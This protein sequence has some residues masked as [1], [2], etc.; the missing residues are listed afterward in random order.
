MKD[1]AWFKDLTSNVK[2]D[3]AAAAVSTSTKPQAFIMKV[4]KRDGSYEEISFDKVLRRIRTLW[5]MHLPQPLSSDISPDEIAQ[6]VCARIY[7]S[8]KTSELD[9]LAAQICAT[10]VTTHPDY[11]V[12]AAR[13]AISNHHKN[14]SP[15]FSET[16]TML[17]NAKDVHGNHNP[18]VSEELMDIVM[19]HRDKL[20]SIIDYDR[21]YSFDYFGFKT[22]ERSYLLKIDK[23]PV[24]RPQHMWMRVALGIHAYDIKEALETYEYMSQRFFTHATPTLF[25]A[26]TPRAQLSSCYLLDVEDSVTGMYKTVSDCAQISKYAGGIGVHIHDIRSRGSHIRGTNGISSGIIPM[27]R[28][29]NNTARHINQAGKRAGSIAMYLEPWHSDVEAFLDIRKNQGAE[30]ERCRDLFTALW[31]PDLFMTRVQQ[32]EEWSL[33]CP[34]RCPGL[35]DV[36]G[37]E[38]DALY[39]KYEAEGRAI[40]KVKAQTI[41]YAILKSQI[42]TG[43]PYLC[44]K[45]ACNKKSNQ[46][47]IGTIK[48]SNLCVAPETMILTD[49]G[50]VCIA[51]LEDQQVFVWN[52]YEFSQTTVRKT[53]TMQKLM[54][55][56]FSNSKTLR[57]TP[58][59][60]FYTSN[61]GTVAADDLVVGT[62]LR[63]YVLPSLGDIPSL[64]MHIVVT[65]INQL[66]EYDDTYCFNE[67]LR[68]AGVFNGILTGQCSEIIE[69][70]DPEQVAS[71]NL[72][73]IGLPTFVVTKTDTDSHVYFDYEALHK[74]SRVVT[75][76]LNKVIDRTFYPIPEARYANLLHRPL[77]IGVQGLADVFALL[78]LPF[79]SPEASEVNRRIFEVIYH[80]CMTESA[81][82]ARRRAEMRAEMRAA[83]SGDDRADALAKHL[84]MIPQEAAL[85]AYPGAY[86]TFV[87]SPVS[88]GVLQFD[89]WGVT[90]LPDTGLDWEGLRADIAKWGIRN[91]LLIANMPTASS[92]QILGFNECFEPFTSNMFQRQTMAGEFTIINKYLIRDLLDLGLWSLDM[93]DRI[94]GGG[95]SVQAIT[96]IPENIRAL[97]KTVWEIKQKVLIDQAAD[98][99]AF[100]C[101]S[102]SLN[103]FVEDTDFNKL[104]SMHFY[105]WKKGLKT[106]VYYLRT[107]PKARIAAYTLAPLNEAV[108][109]TKTNQGP[110]TD[111]V[112]AC[113]RDNPEGCLMCSS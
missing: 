24:E 99:G 80:G 71:C 30:E 26:G 11:G 48:S 91:S 35:S 49:K 105:A 67:P 13:I 38:F 14:T 83:V 65:D 32:N 93:K 43:T 108:S 68:H 100:V 74:V 58:Y 39:E 109:P 5:G 41:W 17:Y 85:T 89:M 57:C 70:S 86:A 79:D 56:H 27:L 2:S 66:G 104:T 12:L 28:V 102:Q 21:D 78:R 50:D 81:A 61:G 22:L 77:G 34:D 106:G 31:I 52:G 62:R 3:L 44:Y 98:R 54:T 42:E 20:N 112:A 82:I 6:K 37:E 4:I 1:G 107:R 87:G 113:R 73:S 111:E 36:Y 55:V 23:K 88:K 103:L 9:E 97:Y 51:D 95:G 75:R 18:L 84:N 46:A 59:H 92:S 76:N 90:P 19:N 40:K 45:D 101:Q 33:M 94:L 53:G 69:Y 63:E 64:P 60:K 96:E 8:V 72:A 7:D 110:S 29:F 15:S 16:V 47:N 10:M 25:N